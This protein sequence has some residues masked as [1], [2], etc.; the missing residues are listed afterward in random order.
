VNLL[1]RVELLILGSFEVVLG[2]PVL[3]VL[4]FAITA[5]R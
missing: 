4:V 5:S 3:D 2:I 1:D